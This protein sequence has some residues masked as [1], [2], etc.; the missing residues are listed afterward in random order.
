M[1][2]ESIIVLRP[3]SNLEYPADHPRTWQYTTCAPLVCPPSLVW[4][5]RQ[6]APASGHD[7]SRPSPNGTGRGRLGPPCRMASLSCLPLCTHGHAGSCDWS[8]CRS[9]DESARD[10][11]ETQRR[12]EEHTSELQS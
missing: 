11:H 2:A 8:G 7:R 1:T 10:S 12:S 5:G 9:T 6:T 4:Y 3:I